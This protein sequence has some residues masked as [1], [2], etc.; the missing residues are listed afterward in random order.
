MKYNFLM[1]LSL[2][3]FDVMAMEHI[4]DTTNQK[5]FTSVDSAQFRREANKTNLGAI[6][7]VANRSD[8]PV[9]VADSG[10]NARHGEVLD[11]SE[12]SGAENIAAHDA[13]DLTG[14]QVADVV[15]ALAGAIANEPSVLS[16]LSKI[17]QL[18]E[19]VL[20]SIAVTLK[21]T[22]RQINYLKGELTQSPKLNVDS[23]LGSFDL[24]TT[25]T[26]WI[27]QFVAW[28]FSSL[29]SES[30]SSASQAQAFDLSGSQPDVMNPLQDQSDVLAKLTAENAQL[31]EQ[32]KAKPIDQV[33]SNG[34]GAAQ[35][36]SSTEQDV[37]NSPEAQALKDINKDLSAEDIGK[38][39]Q[40]I[41]VIRDG[42]FT[43]VSE[44]M[45]ITKNVKYIT[46]RN[47]LY[48]LGL[49]D[50]ISP[51][52]LF[53]I[54][55]KSEKTESSKSAGFDISSAIPSEAK[56][57]KSSEQST[58]SQKAVQP[59]SLQSD[60]P[61]VAKTINLLVKGALIPEN[62]PIKGAKP[63]IVLIKD[64]T[65][66][67][68]TQDEIKKTQSNVI[69]ACKGQAEVILADKLVS[70]EIKAIVKQNLALLDAE[71]KSRPQ[72][73]IIIKKQS[74][75]GATQS[76]T[77]STLLN[78]IKDSA[79]V[80][81]SGK[82]SSVVSFTGRNQSSRVQGTALSNS[83]QVSADAFISMSPE[84]QK[85]AL[86]NI[87]SSAEQVVRQKNMQDVDAQFASNLVEWTK[88]FEI[89]F[90]QNKSKL[91]PDDKLQLMNDHI[92][93]NKKDM[94]DKRESDVIQAGQDAV[95][96][97]LYK[98]DV[99]THNMN[100]RKVSEG[101]LSAQ[102]NLSDLSKSQNDVQQAKAFKF[103]QSKAQND[104][105]QVK[106]SEIALIVDQLFDKNAWR[107]RYVFEHPGLTYAKNGVF[108]D[109]EMA[110]VIDKA[111]QAAY[112][113]PEND[114]AIKK[115][116]NDAVVSLQNKQN[117]LS[118]MSEDI[119]KLSD[120]DLLAYQAKFQ[121]LIPK[122]ITQPLLE[123]QTKIV[124]EIAQ[125]S[126]AK[127]VESKINNDLKQ[128]LIAF[129]GDS[130]LAKQT[131]L[132]AYESQNP[133]KPADQRKLVAAIE[134]LKNQIAS[135]QSLSQNNPNNS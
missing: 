31:K 40:L 14:K 17:G 66:Q 19:S 42:E 26:N 95:D 57:N 122:H 54:A 80:V 79:N 64:D 77:R 93:S 36:Q 68:L 100:D 4:V 56:L 34:S 118:S 70:P 25:I 113:T 9:S 23:S 132:K 103:E 53:N 60:H 105:Q 135:E 39:V 65:G 114:A 7:E 130:L 10:V 55:Q 96:L 128:K 16:N 35:G 74:G 106:K 111:K 41:K 91:S 44:L 108:I 49:P 21:F 102:Q 51:S 45:M 84:L 33:M 98:V 81:G 110:K 50:E 125:R 94:L 67:T 5:G 107:N 24:F 22:Q 11:L 47:Q 97:F 63:A 76:S 59:K 71:L 131:L 30:K 73:E 58:V 87:R 37:L 62:N 83:A 38:L 13:T 89:D 52:L 82:K 112:I 61:V 1:A 116:G 43:N 18:K 126:L 2:I 121:L 29:K 3:F 133:L 75:Q 12:E 109:S 6:N 101:G 27:N 115:A 124:N 88:Q 78:S 104:A 20:N 117:L 85:Q 69:N 28:C 129:K 123:F 8:S 46:L 90:K 92:A 99:A 127:K 15:S 120:V 72:G 86:N 48:N 32:L 119:S 134:E